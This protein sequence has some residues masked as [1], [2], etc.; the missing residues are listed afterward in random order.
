MA[1]QTIQ[2]SALADDEI[3]LGKLFGI[4]I[5]AKWFIIS[6]TLFFCNIRYRGRVAINSDLQSRRVNTNRK[7][8]FRWYLAMVGDMGELFSA[9]SSATTEIEIIKSRM[10]LGDTVDKFNLTTIA[11]PDYLPFVGKGLARI[12]GTQNYI[13]LTTFEVPR[14]AR[15]L[16]HQLIATDIEKGQFSLML[17]DQM[18]LSGSVG[19]LIEMNGYRVK[20]NQLNAQNE[21]TFTISK[22]SKLDA[23]NKLASQL[24][25]SERG[26]QTGIVSLS[27]EGEYPDHNQLVLNDV[28]QNYFLQNVRRNSAEAEQSLNFL[29]GH[30]PE[31]KDKL[32]ISEDTLNSFRQKKTKSIDLN[33]EAQSTLKSDGGT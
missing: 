20:V 19:Q 2:S 11:T 30:L 15:G 21:D 14:T 22:I 26:S 3:D 5:D 29:K 16:S 12:N 27:I 4:L 1:N 33:L 32:T 24:S 25:I 9:E 10:I 23:I 28:V 18:V 7:E 6:I 8:E 13:S 31:I 17:E